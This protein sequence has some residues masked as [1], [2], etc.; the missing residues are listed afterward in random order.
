MADSDSLV[1]E[2]FEKGFPYRLILCCLTACH[3]MRITLSTL[4]RILR[5]LNVRRRGSYSSLQY[6]GDCLLVSYLYMD[7]YMAIIEGVAFL[8]FT[9][10]ISSYASK[11]IWHPHSRIIVLY[12]SICRDVVAGMLSVVDPVGVGERVGERARRVLV[13]RRYRLKKTCKH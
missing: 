11:T 13:R 10:G 12:E 5:R 1:R 3:G 7:R 8:F 6:V 2:Y 9:A 4:K